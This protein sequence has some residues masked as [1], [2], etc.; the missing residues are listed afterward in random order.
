MHTTNR[1]VNGMLLGTFLALQSVERLFQIVH[2]RLIIEVLVALAVQFLQGFQLLHITHTHVRS[3]VEV[4]GRDGL[5]AV[6]L[7]L[8]ALHRDTG[9]HRGRLNTLGRARGTMTGDKATVQN[10]VQRVL[11]TGERL[12]RIIVLVV[13]MQIVVLHGQ[14]TLFREQVVVDE[15]L[16]SLRGKLHHH[17]CR[18]VGIHVGILTR[19][20]IILDVHDIEEHITGLSL[21]GHG[22]LMTVGDVPLG[23]ILA[24]R[25]HQ[26]HLHSILNLFHGHLTLATLGDM[27]GNLVQQAFVLALVCVE[28]GLTD[29][30]HNFLL[31]EAHNA[32]VALNYSLNHILKKAF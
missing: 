31:I 7:V 6:H 32:S 3:E 22:S 24:T 25:L 13:D 1:L 11:H 19:Y 16:R 9:Q 27:V 18:G 14:T 23:H 15:R 10:I 30:C 5:S 28:H 21:T 26:F 12:R 4:E 17:T 20:I 29:G 8:T 2:Q